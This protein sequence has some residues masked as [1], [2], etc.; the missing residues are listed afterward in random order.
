MALWN[1]WDRV[2]SGRVVDIKPDEGL[3]F[4]LPVIF[5]VKGGRK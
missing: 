4:T 1:I 3:A 5:R 2:A